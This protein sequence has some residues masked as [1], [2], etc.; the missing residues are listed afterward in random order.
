MT[1][2][3]C[4]AQNDTSN[5]FCWECGRSLEA[6][7][8]TCGALNPPGKP[9]CGT[10]GSALPGTVATVDPAGTPRTG[11]VTERR[12]ITVLFADLTNY[13]TF[14][15]G[16]DP[17]DVRAFLTTYFD[18]SS[19]VIGRF[20]GIVEKFIGD[21]VMAVWGA[22]QANE[23]DAERAVRAGL[24]LVDTV[25]KV[26]ADAGANLTL[27]VGIHTGDASVGPGG[28]QIAMVA[29]DNVNIAARLQTAASP[30]TVLV[31][32]GT[33]QAAQQA[34]EFEPAGEHEVKGKAQRVVAYQAIRVVAE[35]RGVGRSDQ[36]EPPFVGR[37]EELRLLKDLLGSV[38]RDTRARMVSVIG[39]TGLGKSRL[40][41][42]FQKYIDGLVDE[43]FWH[44]GRSLA[45]R[46]GVTFWAVAEMIRT[47][48]GIADDDSDEV[49]RAKLQAAIDEHLTDP[50]DRDWA[51]PRLAAVLGIGTAPEG[52]RSELDAAVR[53]F[54]EGVTAKGTTVLVFED[55]HWADAALLDFID[56]LP[57]WWS[58]VPIL[59]VAVARP[60][61]TEQRPAWGADRPGT[62]TLHLGPLSRPE[63]V[64]LVNGTTP[65]LPDDAVAAVVDKAAGV[66]LY[67]VELLRMLIARG[68]IVPSGAGYQLVGDLPEEA[69]PDSLQAVIGARLDRL[70][71]DERALL[72]DAAVLGQT[73]SVAGLAAIDP[74]GGD[75]HQARLAQL[76]RRELIEPVRDPRSPQ[77]GQYRFIQSMIRDVALGR[78]SRDT[79]RA[80]HLEVAAYHEQ[81]ADPELAVVVASHYLEALDATPAGT[82]A[83]AIRAK[84]LGS[85]AAAADRAAD[86]RAHSQVMSISNQALALADNP[87]LRAPFW[88]RLAEA[89]NKL[90]LRE[91]SV[92]YGRLVLDHARDSSDR[93][94]V[95]RA[96]RILATIYADE[97]LPH[98]ALALLEP[99]LA[100]HPDLDGDPELV[101]AAALLARVLLLVEAD[102]ASVVAA[103]DRA[104]HAAELSGLTDVLVDA[105]ITKATARG[106][107][108]G[109]VEARILL[110]GA[111]GLADRHALGFS[112]VR[113]RNNLAHL[114]AALDPQAAL[115]TTR[116]AFDLTVRAGN[117]ASA[118]F[119]S[120]GLSI[121]Y[122]RMLDLDA[123][124]QLLA[125]PILADP[126][127]NTVSALLEPRGFLAWVRGD[128][129]QAVALLVEAAGLLDGEADP[130]LAALRANQLTT[131]SRL[132]GNAEEAFASAVAWGREGWS[133]FLGLDNALWCVAILG[134]R[135][136]AAELLEL[137]DRYHGQ[138]LGWPAVLGCIVGAPPDEPLPAADIDE[139][140]GEFDANVM[141]LWSIQALFMAARFSPPAHPD[142]ERWVEEARRRA[143][144]FPGILDLIDRYLA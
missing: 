1:C 52:E 121:I 48:A 113:S 59:V 55:A 68:D 123:I 31:G 130:Q 10:C 65:G 12:L 89:A 78:M 110:E 63:M 22:T 106:E 105:L 29:G 119:V 135:E 104:I 102:E 100:E 30:G 6:P 24:E 79:R 77:H 71:P 38:G 3:N 94:A 28:Q 66:P 11:D 74:G 92:R 14:S 50:A 116:E 81:L 51:M 23:D 54:F 97:W 83:D 33:Y 36:L 87:D 138:V 2:P 114:F 8:E 80:R 122:Q 85:M 129:A 107:P 111:M 118:L 120:S 90:A 16:R 108:G 131:I 27:R 115:Q 57:E 37:R 126:P 133:Q 53:V 137:V 44:E 41:W 32:A 43:V 72:Q 82:E 141:A 9:F 144:E 64:E 136:R 139:T 35:R 128:T 19:E 124:E 67:G 140:V 21:A 142:R 69:V 17:E 76:V 45:Y 134:D 95:T 125:E 20:G 98:E 132:G 39:E 34:I 60:E 40:V 4:G 56:E 75:L 101:R 18:R 112:A 13:T 62:I 42:E 73:F 103:A 61:L 70:G 84:A 47:R 127:G 49:T 143:G 15:E 58:G 109:L 26:A 117:R 86:L 88:E 96:V 46:E 93:H 7:C 25:A 5:R 91:E 99:H